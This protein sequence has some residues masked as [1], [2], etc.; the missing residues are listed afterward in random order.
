MDVDVGPAGAAALPVALS[1]PSAHMD[2]PPH[3]RMR[4]LPV[5]RRAQGSAAYGSDGEQP[6]FEAACGT[7]RM[8]SCLTAAAGL[9]VGGDCLAVA[10]GL[11]GGG[12]GAGGDECVSNSDGGG[13]GG[14]GDGGG[15]DGD[16]NS[17]GG[18]AGDVSAGACDGALVD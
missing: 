15:D 5:A 2:G 7:G 16:S 4:K 8:C 3:K 9:T 12:S 17:E 10:A 18:I 11:G 14:G 13:G 1:D 6:G